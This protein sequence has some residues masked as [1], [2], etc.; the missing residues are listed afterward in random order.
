MNSELSNEAVDVIIS[1]I[2]KYKSNFEVECS[3]DINDATQLFI[4]D[5]LIP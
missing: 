2:D 3:L 1:A 5:M 4:D